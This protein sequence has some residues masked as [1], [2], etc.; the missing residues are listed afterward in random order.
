LKTDIYFPGGYF[1]EKN[2][3]EDW[4]K[5]KKKKHSEMMFLME[6]NYE[7]AQMAYHLRRV[8]KLMN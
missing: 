6:R 7:V 3:G 8:K 4:F 1:F 2:V 5:I